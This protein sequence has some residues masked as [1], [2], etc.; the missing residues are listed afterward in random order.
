MIR[1]Q[2]RIH[3]GGGQF[4]QLLFENAF[5]KYRPNALN[6][7][8]E[9]WDAGLYHNP[10]MW[11]TE[12]LVNALDESE[13]ITNDQ[14]NYDHPEYREGVNWFDGMTELQARIESERYDREALH[15]SY[16][17]NTDPWAMHNIGATFT[18]ALSDPLTFTPFVGAFSKA[19]AMTTRIANRMG[20]TKKLSTTINPGRT[21]L[22][23]VLTRPF[24]PVGY[25]AAE[26]GLAEST[27]Q[28]IKGVSK[29]S[30]G[31]DFDYMAALM[32][33]SIVTLTGGAL[34]LF[35][36]AKNFRKNLSMDEL[37]NAMGKSINDIKQKG[38][39]GTGGSKT[40]AQKTELDLNAEYDETM[41]NYKDTTY[42]DDLDID[43]AIFRNV[44]EFGGDVIKLADDMIDRFKR[45]IK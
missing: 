35:P 20:M 43:H 11:G 33:I 40:K 41:S 10:I 4:G 42:N 3:E 44:K 19:G 26:A 18:S 38:F 25:W 9:T 29:E 13:T 22:L 16:M 39:V 17:K 14:W 32:D 30:S 36:M 31:K 21:S 8:E 7:M 2:Y 1:Q 45:C 5:R 24:K 28:I 34:G 12:I 37:Y 23:G 27:Y 15:S 6:Q